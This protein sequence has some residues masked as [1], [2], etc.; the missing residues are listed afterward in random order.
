[1]DELE[2][3]LR[4]WSTLSPGR[5]YHLM[6]GYNTWCEMPL[7]YLYSKG[8]LVYCLGT[9]DAALDWLKPIAQTRRKA[10]KQRADTAAWWGIY[11]DS[12]S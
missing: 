7:L 12:N 5:D 3:L 4:E 2:A 8:D 10:A 9:V 11:A 6:V 1:V